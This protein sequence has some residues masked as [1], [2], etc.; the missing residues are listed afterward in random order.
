MAIRDWLGKADIIPSLEYQIYIY[1]SHNMKVLITIL[2]L[3]LARNTYSQAPLKQISSSVS[4]LDSIEKSNNKNV[5]ASG[6]NINQAIISL[7]DSTFNLRANNQL[8]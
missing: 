5:K 1:F 7:K 8:F 2:I 6:K 3:L 4:R